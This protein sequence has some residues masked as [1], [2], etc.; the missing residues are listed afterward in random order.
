M[1]PR[2]RLARAL[3]EVADPTIAIALAVGLLSL[4]H[5]VVSL[6]SLAFLAGMLAGIRSRAPAWIAIALVAALQFATW[7][8]RFHLD[9]FLS[10]IGVVL[11]PFG[12]QLLK[13]RWSFASVVG[14][15]LLGIAL[16]VTL[17]TGAIAPH[18]GFTILLVAIA[19]FVGLAFGALADSAMRRDGAWSQASIALVARDLLLGRIT[20]GMIHD[21]A[22]PINVVSM[23]NGNLAYLL[24]TMQHEESA[25]D[26]FEER[27]QRIAG[28]TDKAAHLLHNFRSFGREELTATGVLTVRDA[29]ERTRT[30]TT[31]NV[32]HGGVEVEFTGDA[33]DCIGGEHLGVMQMAVAG[34]LLSAYGGY[35]DPGGERRN[36]TLIVDARLASGTIVLTITALAED[37]SVIPV[38]APDP[39][40]AWLLEEVLASVSGR[41]ALVRDR[42]KP[43][44]IR[45]T[46]P[47]QR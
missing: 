10:V 32:R 28:Q 13:A 20:T 46:L 31:S 4:F 29:L 41:F 9:A 33:L 34:T 30:A 45:L 44:V 5:G 16:A 39:V 36:G 22:Q 14:A 15:M 42:G 35:T 12:S 26:L 3:E 23:A 6:I 24:D 8:H 11:A 38:A 25:R 40:L 21:L 2:Q 1:N 18:T 7:P 27:V 43:A 17:N 37:R 19:A 47:H